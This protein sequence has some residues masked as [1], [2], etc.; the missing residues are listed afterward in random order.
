MGLCSRLNGE[1]RPYRGYFT[2]FVRFLSSRGIGKKYP[3]G[4]RKKR[5]DKVYIMVYSKKEEDI[6]KRRGY[7]LMEEVRQ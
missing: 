1:T 5:L 7:L 2:K 3:V 6:C 4:G